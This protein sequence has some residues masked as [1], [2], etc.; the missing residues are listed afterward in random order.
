MGGS[1][2]QSRRDKYVPALTY[3]AARACSGGCNGSGVG[4]A[5]SYFRG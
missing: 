5:E 1:S 2:E 4:V 3:I